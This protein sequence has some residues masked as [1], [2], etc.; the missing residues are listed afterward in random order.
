MIAVKPKMSIYDTMLQKVRR[1]RVKV[2]KKL[3]QTKE[4]YARLRF[5]LE[6]EE[7][8][9]AFKLGKLIEL[10]RSINN[11]KDPEGA[12]EEQ[13]AP[14]DTTEHTMPIVREEKEE[15]KPQP[16]LAPTPE[17][18]T[19]VPKSI[20]RSISKPVT[21]SVIKSEI[22]RTNLSELEQ[23][24][25]TVLDREPG[26]VFRSWKI[27]EKVAEANRKLVGDSHALFQIHVNRTVIVLANEGFVTK[28]AWGKYESLNK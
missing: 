26:K 19:D 21:K 11:V 27:A 18:K 20:P 28:T 25:I 5:R 14:A 15:N 6:K 13:G 3:K 12:M 7:R 9:L 16:S 1:D 10:E 4:E 24:I 8:L 22:K 23:T 2:E 17:V